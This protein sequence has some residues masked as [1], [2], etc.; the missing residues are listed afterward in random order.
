MAAGFAPVACCT[1]VMHIRSVLLVCNIA[2]EATS[3][4]ETASSV[5]FASRAAQLE[6]GIARRSTSVERFEPSPRSP[7]QGF[8]ERMLPEGGSGGGGA[9]QGPAAAKPTTFTS[10]GASSPQ[11]HQLPPLPIMN[12]TAAKVRPVATG[13]R[14]ALSA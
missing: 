10:L 8:P 12:G 14:K 4:S 5:N 9:S 6:V 13:H 7:G 3:S 1:A 2:P 11:L